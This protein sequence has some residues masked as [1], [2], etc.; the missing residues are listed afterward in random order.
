MPDNAIH[1]EPTNAAQSKSVKIAYA[2]RLGL[3]TLPLTERRRVERKI[4]SLE[5][6][7][8]LAKTADTG[9]EGGRLHIAD[10]SDGVRVVFRFTS[11][12]AEVVDLISK[13][14][15]RQVFGGSKP[16]GNGKGAKVKRSSGTKT[17]HK[18]HLS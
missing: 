4:N 11:T 6:L 2:V 3:T 5:T 18:F 9:G 17:K 1:P 14:A 7:R 8:K 15:F 12:G 10:V 16:G 13:Q